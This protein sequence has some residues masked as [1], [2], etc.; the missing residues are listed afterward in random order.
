MSSGCFECK[1]EDIS[2]QNF[3][4]IDLRAG[5]QG[6][7][8]QAD[9]LWACQQLADRIDIGQAKEYTNDIEDKADF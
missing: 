7:L 4:L 6:V 9:S 2:R 5:P 3:E 1:Q 8:V